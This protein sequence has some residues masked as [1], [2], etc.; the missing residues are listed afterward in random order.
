MSLKDLCSGPNTFMGV[1]Y[2]TEIAGAHAAVLGI[3][4]DKVT[5]AGLF[6]IAYTIGTD[7]KVAKR[8]PLDG[9]LHWDKW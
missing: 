1:P 2:A 8:L 5:Q 3:P 6:P 4:F 9:I 7:F